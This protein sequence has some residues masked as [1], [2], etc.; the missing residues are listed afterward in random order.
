MFCLSL[1]YLVCVAVLVVLWVDI[2]NLQENARSFAGSNA[3]TEVPAPT[4]GA[5]P[6]HSGDP[7][8]AVA[9]VSVGVMFLIWPVVILETVVHWVT[10][11]YTREML[12]YHG[13]GVLF[14]LCPALRMC[15]RSP[16][17]HQRLW[18]PGLGWRRADHRLRR[19]LERLFSVP[20]IIIALLIMPV[21]IVEFFL[22][23]QVA[24][25][26][27]LRILLHVGTGL[28]WFAFAAEFIL[29]VS[30]ADKK[31]TYCKK[32]WLDLAIILLPVI[33]FLRS[34][35]AMR[36]IRLAKVMKIQQLS[37]LARVY[38]LRATAMKV[39][40]AFVV[41]DVFRRIL[42]TSPEKSITRLQR[43]LDEVENEAKR[44]RRRIAKL[45]REQRARDDASGDRE[46]VETASV[47]NDA[48]ES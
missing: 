19:R 37:K 14:C 8:H 15:A 46:S 20:M 21:L 44:L 13:F 5:L 38:R 42:K 28:I 16:E 6:I 43:Q 9:S 29:M 11:P 45:R 2:P 23:E 41:L 22:K 30:V 3:T 48:V 25:H 24:N 40:R 31:L 32:N 27:W 7:A 4:N 36:A 39:V 33:S 18:L 47:A 26:L 1:T 12:R 35:Q 10:R 34:L 17:M